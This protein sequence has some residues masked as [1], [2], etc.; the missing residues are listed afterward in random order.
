MNKQ[1]YLD[2]LMYY[3]QGLPISEL[4][5]IFSDYEEH[6]RMGISKGKSEEEISKEL[7]DPME[8]ANNY[9]T[10]Y[11]YND[12]QNMDNTNYS[13]NDTK[14]LL[15]TIGLIAFNI[16]IVAGPYLGLA[17]VL[18]SFYGV[19]ISIIV[20]GFV[21]LFGFPISIFTPIPT[22]HILTS[23]AFGIGLLALG[24]LGIIL[25]VY[26]TKLLYQLTIKYIK[27]NLELINKLGGLENEY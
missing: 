4:E 23:I 1:E 18:L 7:G 15:V 13:S 27:W 9:K 20:S 11:G 6:F 21:V 8:V 3:L 10:I 14:R 5:D 16:I 12:T 19:G 24:T 2:R 26:L 22:P 17:G 25:S